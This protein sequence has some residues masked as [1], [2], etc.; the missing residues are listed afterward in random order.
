MAEPI[1]AA[2]P[3][4]LLVAAVVGIIVLLLLIVKFKIH[5]VLSLLISAL[6]IGLG[7]GMSVS[8]LVSTVEKGAGETLQGIVL[9]IGLGSL[10]GGILEVSG[11]AQCVAQTLIE[12]FG[13]EKAGVALGITG[14]VVGTTVFFEAGVVILI[15]LAFGLAK[16]T[17]KS[18]LHYVIPLLAGLATGFAY[19]PPSAGSVLVANMLNVDLGIMIAVGVPVGILSMIFAG[20]LW[21]KYI[22]NKINTGLPS[23]IQ[24]VREAEEAQLPKFS[25][26]LLIVLI[27]L[28]LILFNTV[29]EYIPGINFIRP[30]LE[31]LGTPFVALII[32]VLFAMYFLGKKQGYTGEQLKKIMDRSLK[33]TGQILLVITG[34]G[35]IRWV[36][37]DCGMGNII[38]PVLEKS[39]L[40]LVIVAFLIA[41]LIRASVGAAVVAMTMAAGIMASMPGVAELSPVYLAAMVCAINGGATAFSHVNDSGFWLVNSL[42]EIDEKTTLKSWTIMETIVGLTGLVCAI[43]ISLFV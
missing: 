30:V 38:G 11:G 12:K 31:F 21:S 16:K 32:A 28:V 23:S 19:I 13:E 1:F 39:G 17:K 20:I 15:P 24:E 33:P 4:R 6:F 26:V 41:A 43:L 10:F 14:L 18:T 42:L 37:Q 9:L 22:G 40:P 3:V 36:L 2:E 35:I 7:A 29:S 34:G 8:S 5:P 25:T 27:P